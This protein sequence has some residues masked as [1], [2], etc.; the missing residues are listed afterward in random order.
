[1]RACW[2]TRP[3]RPAWSPSR[4][5]WAACIALG[6][7]G[8][9][10]PGERLV[11]STP[12]IGLSLV[13]GH[14]SRRR[15]PGSSARSACRRLRA[16]QRGALDLDPALRG[17][18]ALGRSR[19]LRPDGPDRR[20]AGRRRDRLADGRLGPGGLTRPWTGW[21][22]PGSAPRSASRPSSSA[23]ATI[24]SAR[25]RT[26]SASPVGHASWP[27]LCLYVPIAGSRHEVMMETDAIRDRFWEAFDRFVAAPDGASAV[28][29]V[30]D[31]GVEQAVAGGHDRGRRRR[32]IRRPRWSRC[33]PRLRRWGSGPRCR[34][35]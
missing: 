10:L 12:M 32:L 11:A 33:R 17:Q 3:P 30:E 28:Q 34:R 21:P 19:P 4:I 31:L 23:R 35:A 7:G 8:G 25:R 6:G 14:A 18:P 26:S 16:G 27:A 22:D 2:R 9:W 5:P 13:S 15:W 20:G 1:M 29:D 24:P